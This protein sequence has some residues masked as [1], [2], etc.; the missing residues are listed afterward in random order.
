MDKTLINRSDGTFAKLLASGDSLK[1]F[2]PLLIDLN[3]VLICS[4]ALAISF[5]VLGYTTAT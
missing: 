1:L 2:A 3:L 5:K 4:H